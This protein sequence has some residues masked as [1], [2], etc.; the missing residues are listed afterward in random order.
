MFVSTFVPIHPVE[1]EIFDKIRKPLTP[2]W[3][4]PKSLE[5]IFWGTMKACTKFKGNPSNGC[6]D[7]SVWTQLV[8]WLTAQHC[9]PCIHTVSV[10]KTH[11]YCLTQ[12]HWNIMPP[13]SQVD[14]IKASQHV[15]RYECPRRIWWWPLVIQI[16]QRGNV[17]QLTCSMWQTR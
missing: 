8:N 9:H 5:F 1:V 14:L 17:T 16:A 3:R 11:S 10:A 6:W 4:S 12:E 13:F 15:V 2:W 7:I